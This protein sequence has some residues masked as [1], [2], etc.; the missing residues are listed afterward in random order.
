M[1][2]T[3][4]ANNRRGLNAW[5]MLFLIGFALVTALCLWKAPLEIQGQD[6]AFYL[7]IPQRL[8]NGDAFLVDEWHG[9]QLSAFI[10]Y[11]LFRLHH[12][13]L[14][15]DGIVLHFRYF[16]VLC[17]ALCAA[18]I[19]GRL[20]KLGWSA[21]I[22]SLFFYLFTPYDIMALSYNT[23]GLMLVTLTG[24]NLAVAG[25]RKAYFISG[26]LFAGAVL[27]CP[28]L[29]AGY[30]AYSVAALLFAR[31]KKR[32][33]AARQ[34]L[35][36]TLGAL[37]VAALLMIF[38]LTR[39][40]LADLWAAL[41][42]LLADPEHPARPF[43][44][45]LAQYGYSAMHLFRYGA[46]YLAADC[47]ALVAAALDRRRYARKPVY[48]AIA[49]LI[50]AIMLI[51]L[52]PLAAAERYNAV[53]FPL[54]PVGLMAHLVTEHKA[55]RVFLF[56]YLGG[57]TYTLCIFFSSNQYAQVLPAMSTAA[58]V[59]SILLLGHALAEARPGG[60]E[61]LLRLLS[62]AT[63]ALLLTQFALMIHTKINHKFLSQADNSA[64][65]QVIQEGPYRGIRVTPD[66]E[67]AYLAEL[68]PL[69]AMADRQGTVLYA[70][71][72]TWYYLATPGLG[73]GAYS[74]WLPDGSPATLERLGLYYRLN[75]GK[76]PDY[77]LVPEHSRWDI[78]LLLTLLPDEY[79]MTSVDG[80]VI[81]SRI[82]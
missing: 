34:W 17:Q 61:R 58:N 56:T 30:I 20:R 37:C 7:T 50:S 25:S 77:I 72:R 70:S 8:L 55:R 12:M 69:Q 16:Y 11:P 60:R 36:F 4:H 63:A 65:T 51:D 45:T 28:Y 10:L 81:Y 19:Y 22:A 29:I 15:F 57:M 78:A 47:V 21:V 1:S 35:I 62:A 6:E 32:G 66:T 44:Y 68:A 14:G 71:L 3:Q 9:S 80:A 75:P 31:V 39:A 41:P 46:I 40:S 49:M 52:A 43:L 74:A 18:V 73:I 82:H 59:G 26:V 64:L 48:L 79:A 53:M 67:A 27:C 23:M 33:E 38:A 54:A 76:V 24:V 2:H 13:L 42:N 5:D